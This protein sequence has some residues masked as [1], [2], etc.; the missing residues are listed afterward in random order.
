[1][2]GARQDWKNGPAEA[3]CRLTTARRAFVAGGP[4][5]KADDPWKHP[6]GW[7]GRTAAA[8]K[9]RGAQ[10]CIFSL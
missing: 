1:M 6:K 2:P 5:P 10:I 4:R 7:T 3:G 9:P 8:A